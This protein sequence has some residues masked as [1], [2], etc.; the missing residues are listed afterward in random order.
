MLG[1]LAGLGVLLALSSPVLRRRAPYVWWGMC[2]YPAGAVR[3]M[4]TWRRLADLQGLSVAKRPPLALLGGVVLKG[5]A[6][7]P[8]K[9][10]MGLPRWKRGGLVVRVRLHP[11]QI[12][13]AYA[14][15]GEA[16][17]HA[18]RVFAVRVASDS[19]G[20]VVLT[21]TAWDPLASPS[22]P[23]VRP[24]PLLSASVGQWEDGRAWVVNLRRVPH[25]LIVGATRSGKS[26]LMASLV[27]QWAP[28]RVALVG[29]DLKGG[30][31]LSLFGARLSA[32]AT[33]RHEAAELLGR[34]VEITTARMER[35]RAAGVRSVWELPGKARP[36]PVVVLVDEVAEL[37]L[38]ASSADK[39]EVAQV[40]TALLRLAQLGAAL[41]VHLVVAG[42][43]VGSDLGPGVTA[44]RAQLAGRV[45]H[46]VMDKGTAEMALGD[47]DPGAVT[48]AQEITADQPGVA[49]AF[50][51]DGGW[52][53]AR[54]LLTT[55]GQ[56]RR[57][58][59]RH[60]AL[61]P[62]FAELG[63]AS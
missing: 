32:L 7:K 33:S 13:E 21:A 6:L 59:E 46:R 8:V 19:R 38:M 1:A 23:L 49:V 40:S 63:S 9:P 54:S 27:S 62:S 51:D 15:A 48:A 16:M 37:Y 3:V 57:V 50:G 45:C 12:P 41:G 17:A 44:L 35:C 29:I 39:A 47:L 30:M 18:W 56:A 61:A 10:R 58:A 5:R 53:R 11:G 26:T 43:R 22:L 14:V 34:L 25:W 20:F 42:Q 28:Q 52:M 31:E 36:V 4:W 60:A 24:G 55:P 2:G